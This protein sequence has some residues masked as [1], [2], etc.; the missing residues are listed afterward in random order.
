[1]AVGVAMLTFTPNYSWYSGLLLVLV[2]LTGA[3]EWLPVVVAPTFAY[4]VHSD[5]DQ[6][7][8]LIALI[9]WAV[10]SLVRH[11]AALRAGWD[12]FRN[13]QEPV[14]RTPA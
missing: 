7:W 8:Y 3:L 4:L 6:L 1:M 9:L 14:A 2:A 11:H 5:H 12:R 10:L 13:R